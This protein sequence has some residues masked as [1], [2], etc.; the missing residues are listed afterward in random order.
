M[1]QASFEVAARLEDVDDVS[2]HLEE[3]SPPPTKSA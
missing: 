1:N 3:V 2:P